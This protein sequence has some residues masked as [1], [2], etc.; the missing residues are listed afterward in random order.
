MYYI[1]AATNI[2][3]I[4]ERTYAQSDAAMRCLLATYDPCH[5]E[6]HAVETLRRVASSTRGHMGI[7]VAA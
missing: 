6:W 7:D 3:S 5:H 2:L 1:Y 4:G